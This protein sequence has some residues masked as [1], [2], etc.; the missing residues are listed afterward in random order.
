MDLELLK[1]SF[2]IGI[3]GAGD[4]GHLYACKFREAGWKKVNICDLPVRYEELLPKYP[5]KAANRLR[6]TWAA[7]G[8]IRLWRDGYAVTRRSDYIIYSVEAE[9]IGRAVAQYGPASKVGAVVGGQVSYRT[10]LIAAKTSV[11]APEIH[12]FE[13]HLPADTEIVTCHSMHGPNVDPTAQPLAVIPYRASQR[14]VDRVVAI[15]KS[16]KSKLVF[17]TPEEHDRI[18]ANTQAVTHLA[19]ISMGTAWKS[20]RCFPWETPN[21][22]GGIENVKVNTMLRIFSNKW[23]VYAGLAMLNPSALEQTQGYADSVR[24]LFELMIQEKEPQFRKRIAQAGE[25]VFGARFLSPEAPPGLLLSNEILDQF[26][27][28]GVP[29]G[30][31]RPNSHLSLLA[32]VSCWVGLTAK[33]D[34]WFR[35]GIN[36]YDHIICQ[37]P[38]FR[39]WLGIVESLFTNRRLMEE[40][41]ACALYNKANRVDDLGQFFSATQDWA[42]CIGH[43]V[44]DTYRLKFSATQDFFAPRL[45][46]GHRL[47]SEMFKVIIKNTPQ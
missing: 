9:N 44:M 27:L 28:S 37:T 15:L 32:I 41:I 42:Q 34:C 1:E 25:F 19:F 38:P 16:L 45:A 43:G 18:T 24:E 8:G 46:D 11:K 47:A 5:G 6:L 20:R 13:A 21:Y 40:T 14:S 10:A 33:V 26:S 23:H 30:V 39:V 36:P 17:L 3:V 31:R 22:V 2:E 35:L 12:A 7:G 29:D 4:M